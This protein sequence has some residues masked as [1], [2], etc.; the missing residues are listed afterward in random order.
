MVLAPILY[1]T[2]PAVISAT[3][4]IYVALLGRRTHKIVKGNG[5]GDVTQIATELLAYT[6]AHEFTHAVLGHRMTVLE[7]ARCWVGPESQQ[8]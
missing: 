1:Y 3:A 8:P 6:K 2:V 4:T 5:G 7:E